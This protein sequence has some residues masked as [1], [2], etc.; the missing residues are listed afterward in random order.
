MHKN[1]SDNAHARYLCTRHTKLSTELLD[2][3]KNIRVRNNRWIF[4]ARPAQFP[5]SGQN[6]RITRG[7]SNNTMLSQIR[8]DKQKKSEPSNNLKTTRRRLISHRVGSDSNLVVALSQQI[9]D[10]AIRSFRLAM[11]A[12]PAKFVGDRMTTI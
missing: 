1:T 10:A 2:T 8:G 3:P 11:P 7:F 9:N 12:L 6:D 5:R 4:F